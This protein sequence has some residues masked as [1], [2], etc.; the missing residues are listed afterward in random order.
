LKGL[1]YIQNNRQLLSVHPRLIV[2]GP[3]RDVEF[4]V[5]CALSATRIIGTYFF[6]KKIN[7]SKVRWRDSD[8][9]VWKYMLL[10]KE[11]ELFKQY[12]TN[13]HAVYDRIS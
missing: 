7:F 13:A 10:G 3:L 6:K 4:G 8:V 9:N 1:T 12:G 5:W 11:I 2:E